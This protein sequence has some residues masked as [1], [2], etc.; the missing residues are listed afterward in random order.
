M[1]GSPGPEASRDYRG[2][3]FS[4]NSWFTTWPDDFPELHQ[5]TSRLMPRMGKWVQSTPPYSSHSPITAGGHTQSTWGMAR[6]CL[7]L[8]ARGDYFWAIQ[9]SFYRK[10]LFQDW[11]VEGKHWRQ[12]RRGCQRMRWLNNIIKSK[13]TNPSKLWE[14]TEDREDWHASVHGVCRTKLS[15]GTRRSKTEEGSCFAYYI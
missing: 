13:D 6:D 12:R 4:C 14:I 7:D 3:L 2:P 15:D 5:P 10:P 11:T 8:L 1:D 9:N